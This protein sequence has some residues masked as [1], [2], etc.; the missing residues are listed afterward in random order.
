MSSFTSCSTCSTRSTMWPA[1]SFTLWN[2]G[3]HSICL[4]CGLHAVTH[5]DSCAR[6]FDFFWFRFGIFIFCF[7]LIFCLCFC[8][9]AFCLRCCLFCVGFFSLIS[10]Y[11]FSSPGSPTS[12]FFRLRDIVFSFFV[13]QWL[14]FSGVMIVK[15][16]ITHLWSRP[17]WIMSLASASL[18]YFK[19]LLSV[20]M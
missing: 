7:L 8:I 13:L 18:L 15:I 12:I 16:A 10:L 2:P 1:S 11:V 6:S 5:H 9:F 3:C 14:L 17:M 4:S 20:K 19:Y